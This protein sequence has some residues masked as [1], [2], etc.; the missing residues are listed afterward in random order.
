MLQQSPHA[1]FAT[2]N[3]GFRDLKVYCEH[4]AVKRKAAA[5]AVRDAADGTKRLLSFWGKLPTI[6]GASGKDE[7]NQQ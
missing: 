5:H 2:R 1:I 3:C 4:M 7:F 6:D